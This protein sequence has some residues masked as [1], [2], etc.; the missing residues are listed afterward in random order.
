MAS[1]ARGGRLHS[2]TA[3]ERG[4]VEGGAGALVRDIGTL[5]ELDHSRISRVELAISRVELA[6]SRTE[7]GAGERDAV[8]AAA[9]GVEA[10]R[11][12]DFGSV[13]RA[14]CMARAAL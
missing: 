12:V 4:A 14:V 10:A 8:I 1:G 6:I 9:R 13:V 2:G 7:L 3:G 11:V 5:C